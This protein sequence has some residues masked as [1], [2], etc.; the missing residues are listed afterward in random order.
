MKAYFES[1]YRNI[2]EE[3]VEDVHMEDASS[4]VV[5]APPMLPIGQLIRS[6]P[7]GDPIK[8]VKSVE[9]KTRSAVRKEECEKM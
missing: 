4:A 1:R 6:G 2:P 3:P 8:C 9:R 5:A 7:F